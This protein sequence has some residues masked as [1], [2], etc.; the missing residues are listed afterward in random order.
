MCVCVFQD[1]HEKGRILNDVVGITVENEVI[2]DLPEQIRIAFHHDV[3]PVSLLA[4]V[5]F[6]SLSV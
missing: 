1:G 5:H 4:F 3:I 2:K 6:W